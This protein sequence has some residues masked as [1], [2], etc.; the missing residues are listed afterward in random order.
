[1][2]FYEVVRQYYNYKVD[3]YEGKYRKGE[4]THL[5]TGLFPNLDIAEIKNDLL[6]IQGVL[7]EGQSVL[8]QN[9]IDLI[10]PGNPEILDIGCG[11][12]GTAF[13]YLNQR[14]GDIH[15]LTISDRQAELVR[16]RAGKL[17]IENRIRII[18]DNI[19]THDFA[20]QQ[21]DVLLGVESF[22]Q[23]DHTEQLAGVVER[24]LKPGGLLILSDYYSADAEFK[25]K[26]DLHW[27]CAVKPFETLVDDF[28][29]YGVRIKEK[30][31][32]TRIQA[33]FW[34]LSALH[35]ELKLQSPLPPE[36][37]ERITASKAFHEYMYDAF[38][39]RVGQYY[40]TV[41]E[42]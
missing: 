41:F 2:N 27:R 35:S 8:T 20:E 6:Q 4:I 38:M 29:R 11:H 40:I 34:K 7:I 19:L 9:I 28:K 26:F 5:H 32:L 17:G 18:T 25:Q 31:D 22:C 15:A 42:K 24:I 12:G 23:I 36:E 1:M 39:D 30:Q 14:A 10:P 3:S 21:F 13:H 37:K 16:V 33:P